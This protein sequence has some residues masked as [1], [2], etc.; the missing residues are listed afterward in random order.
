MLII[1]FHYQATDTVSF[2]N[3]L[4]MEN[5]IW[6]R[7]QASSQRHSCVILSQA[8]PVAFLQGG[9]AFISCQGHRG[10]TLALKDL[11]EKTLHSFCQNSWMPKIK[12]HRKLLCKTP[13]ETEDSV[14]LKR[15]PSHSR[16]SCYRLQY[17]WG[18]SGVLQKK[19]FEQTNSGGGRRQDCEQECAF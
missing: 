5:K 6:V 10:K 13:N 3:S 17:T 8:V 19:L 1:I 11:A 4:F 9:P 14:S 12:P 7:R 15:S 18:A 2:E 16:T